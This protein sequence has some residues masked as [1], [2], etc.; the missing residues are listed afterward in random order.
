MMFMM[1]GQQDVEGSKP[2]QPCCPPTL[3]NKK[4]SD[5]DRQPAKVIKSST[6]PKQ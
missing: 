2:D 6:G 3:T 4:R 1:H 5:K